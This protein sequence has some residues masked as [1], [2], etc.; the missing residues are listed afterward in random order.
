MT[1]KQKE[2]Y[3]W[4][5]KHPGYLKKSASI[6]GITPFGVG[7]DDIEDIEIALKR[8]R[9]DFKST[10]SKT[11]VSPLAEFKA[12]INSLKIASKKIKRLYIDLET[13]PNIVYSWSIGYN[14]TLSHDN[15]IKERSIICGC[16]KWEGESTVHSL[17]WN[18]GDDRE[19]VL[20]FAEILDSADEIIGHNGDKYDLKF[21]RARAI[22]HNITSLP[23]FKTIDTLKIARKEFRFNSNRLDYIGQYL[24][25]GRKMET[26]GFSLW[27]DVMAGS[28]SALKKMIDYCKQDVLLLEKVYNKLEGYTK[29]KTNLAL[30]NGGD[31]CDCPKCASKK[32]HIR[33]N[34]I[35][36][37][38]IRKKRLQ[39]QDCGTY[40]QVLESALKAKELKLV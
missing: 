4:L 3:N 19:L 9:I 5:L 10:S 31:K 17:S 11:S 36:A 30:L 1:K 2:I 24:G 14:L 40:F 35:S 6:I 34:S 8:A 16:Y 38:G 39:C 13:S 21:F 26:G 23:E 37:T 29:P 22:F 12:A 7:F 18:N 28:E 20:K 27:K 32:V 33:G 25:L 15:L